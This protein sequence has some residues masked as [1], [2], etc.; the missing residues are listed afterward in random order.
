MSGG[1]EA[2]PVEIRISAHEKSKVSAPQ[3]NIAERNGEFGSEKGQTGGR[4]GGTLVEPFPTAR[5]ARRP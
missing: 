1:V 5:P 4:P 3:R 2:L